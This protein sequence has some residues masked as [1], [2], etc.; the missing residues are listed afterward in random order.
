MEANNTLRPRLSYVV[1]TDTYDTIR[2]VVDHVRRQSVCDQIEFV[3]VAPSKEV[4]SPLLQ[5]RDEFASVQIVEYPSDSLA[6]ARAAGIRAATAPVVFVGETHSY[7]QP[8]MVERLL[9]HAGGP[10]AVVVPGFGNANPASVLSQAGFFLDY[11]AWLPGQPSREISEYPIYNAAFRRSSLVG[12]GVKLDAAL[13]HGDQLWVALR[14]RDEKVFLEPEARLHHVNVTGFRHWLRERV[15]TGVLIAQH[16]S[17]EWSL[18]RRIAYLVASPLIPFVLFRRIAPGVWTGFRQGRL[19][20][21]GVALVAAG[22]CLKAAG[23]ALIY[24]GGR[25]HGA[26]GLMHEYEMHKLAYAGSGA[27]R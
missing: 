27:P 1:V 12:L 15:L 9:E 17:A 22:V 6:P 25:W 16:R 3:L 4:A 11:G 21:A 19:G 5:H 14:E 18:G 20:I 10:W 7:P 8:Q 2:G 13:S 24:A 23:E 26:E